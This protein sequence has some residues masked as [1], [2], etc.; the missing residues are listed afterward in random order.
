MFSRSDNCGVSMI[1]AWTKALLAILVVVLIGQGCAA[2]SPNRHPSFSALA[3][4][5]IRVGMLPAE[6]TKVFGEPDEM[7][8]RPFGENTSKMWVGLVYNYHMVQDPL[9]EYTFEMLSNTFVFYQGEYTYNLMREPKLNHWV[10][11]YR[12]GDEIVYKRI[13]RPP[14]IPGESRMYDPVDDYFER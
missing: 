7:I 9:Y 13:P 2:G 12:D 6:I 14:R 5:E 11:R 1:R 3:V 8:T 10:I 4:E